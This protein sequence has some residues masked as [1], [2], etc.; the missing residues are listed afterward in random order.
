MFFIEISR[1][2]KNEGEE[3]EKRAGEKENLDS[4]L[5]IRLSSLHFV[6]YPFDSLLCEVISTDKWVGDFVSIIFLCYY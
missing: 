4:Y 2:G 3:K 6:K 1:V 5:A